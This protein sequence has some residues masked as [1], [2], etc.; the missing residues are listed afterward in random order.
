MN[1]PL[2]VNQREYVLYH[3]NLLVE[4][5]PKIRERFVFGQEVD[6]Q[7]CFYMNPD[8]YDV[9]KV[10]NLDGT[11]ILFPGK[12][13]ESIY[14]MKSGTLRIKHDLLKSAFYLLSGYQEYNSVEKDSLGRFPYEASIQNELNII[15]RP[16]VNEYFE[17]LIEAISCFCDYHDLDFCRRSSENKAALFLTHD[18]DRIDKFTFNTIKGAF[19]KSKL[20]KAIKWMIK[21]I[22]PF[23][24]KNP[25]W[26]FDYL[27]KTE[28]DRGLHSCYFFLKKD[29]KHQDSYYSFSDKRIR[30]LI[31]SLEDKGHSI[32]IHGGV[33]SSA[34]SYKICKDI[35]LLNAVSK[36]EVRGNRQHRL[37][38]QH[39]QT[40]KYL[41]ENDILFDSSLG[42]AQHEGFRNSYCCPFKLYDFENDCM[43]NVWELPLIVM[44]GTLFT[45]RGLTYKE[46]YESIKKLKDEVVRYCGVFTLL[47]HQDFLD[48]EEHPGIRQ[49]YEKVLDLLSDEKM[50]VFDT[51]TLLDKDKAC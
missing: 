12:D 25:K 16:I 49:F 14:E 47:F 34:D 21:W 30:K 40:M 1:G 18:V 26:T 36:Q 28:K 20:S 50:E 17:I 38:Y 7:I 41:E 42:Y 33:R 3:L 2:T 29:V 4:I 46:A 51:Q 15:N 37:L 24:T 19:K 11:P 8:N 35:A 32:G 9:A 10:L 23:Y 48:E 27:E 39:P 22:N 44:D 43:I 31:A 5:S 6:E 13:T 45:Y